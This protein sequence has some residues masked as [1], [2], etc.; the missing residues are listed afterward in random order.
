MKNRNAKKFF[1]ICLIALTTVFIWSNSFKNGESSMNDSNGIKQMIISFFMSLGIDIEGTFFIEFIRKFG[2]FAEYFILGFEL[3]LYK[4]MF[5]KKDICSYV[6]VFFYGVFA[7][8]L[9]ETIQLIPALD[10]SAEVKDVWIDIFGMV[11]AF[12]IVI[13]IH[14]ILKLIKNN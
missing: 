9:D 3:V 7:A 10:R 4:I 5:L 8:F 6:N 13:L 1:L 14:I 11:T 2:H 12:V